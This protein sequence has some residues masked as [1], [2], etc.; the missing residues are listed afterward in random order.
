GQVPA[1][2]DLTASPL[3]LAMIANVHRYRGALPGSRADLYAEICQVMLG[4]REAQNVSS[5]LPGPWKEDILRGLAYEMMKSHV[6]SLRRS[7]ILQVI[8]PDLRRVSGE[9]TPD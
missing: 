3:L 9:V 7:D 2:Q 6:N 4:R 1:L 8:R 5:R